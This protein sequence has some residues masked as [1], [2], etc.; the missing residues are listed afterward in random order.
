MNT[1]DRYTQE[2]PATKDDVYAAIRNLMAFS[3]AFC[4]IV[5]DFL[6]DDPSSNIM[7]AA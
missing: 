3:K 6:G 2:S 1:S 5:P 4:K 7:H